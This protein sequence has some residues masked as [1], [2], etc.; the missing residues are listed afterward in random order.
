MF[1]EDAFHP[2]VHNLIEATENI[3]PP[4]DHILPH[5]SIPELSQGV[6]C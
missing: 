6:S 3:P 2:E 5:P 4:S 1:V